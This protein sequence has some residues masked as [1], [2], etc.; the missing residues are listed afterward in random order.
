[1]NGDHLI[2]EVKLLHG[3]A[4]R[5]VET[6]DE[7]HREMAKAFGLGVGASFTQLLAAAGERQARSVGAIVARDAHL[8]RANRLEDTL[9]GV[10]TQLGEGGY[11]LQLHAMVEMIDKAL[12]GELG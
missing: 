2:S 9:R 3:R 4:I 5:A 6:L 12:S 7:R 11:S 1:M 8:A 10:R